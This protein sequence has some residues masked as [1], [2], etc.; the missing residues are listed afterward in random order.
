MNDA[1][2]VEIPSTR[3]NHLHPAIPCAPSMRA[4]MAPA[5]MPPKAPDMMPALRKIMKRLLCS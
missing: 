2:I 1:P 3:N 4:V 5:T